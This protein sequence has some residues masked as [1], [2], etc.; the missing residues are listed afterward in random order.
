MSLLAAFRRDRVPADWAAKPLEWM[1]TVARAR[2]VARNLR[3]GED[4]EITG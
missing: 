1:P 2:M 3:C 4:G